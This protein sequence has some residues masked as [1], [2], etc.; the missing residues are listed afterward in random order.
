MV[1]NRKQFLFRGIQKTLVEG[2]EIE[3]LEI[4]RAYGDQV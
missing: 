1:Y 3:C 4:V 2:S